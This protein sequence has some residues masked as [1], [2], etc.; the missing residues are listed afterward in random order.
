MT[1]RDFKAFLILL[2]YEMKV[3]CTCVKHAGRFSLDNTLDAYRGYGDVS[4]LIDLV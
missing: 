3:S 1:R 2:R 4:K